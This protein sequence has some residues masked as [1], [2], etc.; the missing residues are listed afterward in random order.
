MT[1]NDYITITDSQVMVG[2]KPA[3]TYRGRQISIVKVLPKHLKKIKQIIKQEYGVELTEMHALSSETRGK[4][5][6]PG[7]PS[8][9]HGCW[10]WV[11]FVLANGN[12]TPWVFLL[13]YDSSDTCASRC[14]R[15]C[16]GLITISAD[17]RSA[18]FGSFTSAPKTAE[19]QITQNV[20]NKS[21]NITKLKT[22]IKSSKQKHLSQ[23]S[24]IKKSNSK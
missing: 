10:G 8:E 15:T 9:K 1:I 3:T 17:F 18:V 2:G 12:E 24:L 11:R 5:K 7:N 6:K 4:Y 23:I 20:A 14:A 19:K 21:D 13:G 16:D 22:E